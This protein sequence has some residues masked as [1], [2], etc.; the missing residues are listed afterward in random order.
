MPDDAMM[1]TLMGALEGTPEPGAEPE[2]TPVA[3]VPIVEPVAEPIAEAP[4]AEATPVAEAEAEVEEAEP[5]TPEAL[6]KGVIDPTSSRGKQI[7][8][9]Y[10]FVKSLAEAPKEDGSGG[11]GHI[12]TVDDIKSYH[13]DHITLGLLIDDFE[14]NPAAM[15]AGLS[16]VNPEAT[17]QMIEGLPQILDQLSQTNPQIAKAYDGLYAKVVDDLVNGIL[18]QY[19]NAE[20]ADTK[21]W[22]FAT[23]RNIKYFV[24]NGQKQ[25][26]EAEAMGRKPEADPYAEERARI[27][28]D[29]KALRDQAT[30]REQNI[31]KGFRGA[32]FKELDKVM[33][34]AC[35]WPEELKAQLGKA[36]EPT[37][38]E[39]ENRIYEAVKS[40]PSAQQ[41]ISLLFKR[42]QR[43]I[44]TGGNLETYK[45]QIIKTYMKYAAPVAARVRAETLK[46]F[47]IKAV[48]KQ[49]T[50]KAAAGVPSK[51]AT[52]VPSPS[53]PVRQKGETY[54]DFAMRTILGEIQ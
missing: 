16:S 27:E 49:P 48:A 15:I 43:A 2:A 41:E 12:P 46:D 50:K 23:A 26:T 19:R 11:I 40:S 44:A 52:T 51:A 29:K 21:R 31:W 7:W 6:L 53:K 25:L 37:L 10:T 17:V 34:S 14:S 3:E 1:T 30:A 42:A 47:S 22:Y 39:A 28:A 36:A 38:R 32:T 33:T 4:V 20:D 18:A 13:S 35:N 45:A 5:E 9:G 8:D 54:D 24:T